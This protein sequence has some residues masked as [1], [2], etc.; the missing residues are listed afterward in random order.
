MIPPEVTSA[1]VIQWVRE[2]RSQ[3]KKPKIRMLVPPEINNDIPWAYFDGASQGDP[4]LGGLGGVLYL[5]ENHKIQARFA[6]G[7]C[8]NNKVELAALHLV[9]NLAINNNISQLQVFGD[10][11]MVVDWVNRKIQINAPH[12]QQLL[13]AIRRLL[14]FFTGFRISHICRE[15]NMEV[16][17]LSM[18]ALL[19]DLGKME[20]EEISGI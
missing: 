9:L 19:L 1:L 12:L 16:D 8:T 17:G 20:T 7:N 13:N 3:E 5:S 4:P 11:K 2:H 18:L 15:L 6:P 10:S 14:E